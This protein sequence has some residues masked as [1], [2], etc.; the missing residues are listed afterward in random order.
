MQVRRA[1]GGDKRLVLRYFVNALPSTRTTIH[2]FGSSESVCSKSRTYS[3]LK[4]GEFL[5]PDEALLGVNGV[6]HF[7]FA[8]L[9]FLLSQS[10]EDLESSDR[11]GV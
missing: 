9:S 6:N 3:N 7:E 11:D 1:R 4:E 2:V 10:A 5:G 8:I